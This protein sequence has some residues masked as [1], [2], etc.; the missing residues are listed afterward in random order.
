LAYDFDS[1]P[2]RSPPRVDTPAQ[3][4]KD[5]E[6]IV[7]LLELAAIFLTPKPGTMFTFDALIEQAH[8]ISGP[9]CLIDPRDARIVLPFMKSIRK[10]GRGL[11]L[12]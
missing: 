8:E 9:D 5:L 12:A 7:T 10:R 4:P 2:G 11:C 1:T 6:A 3:H